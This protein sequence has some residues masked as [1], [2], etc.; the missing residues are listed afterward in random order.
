MLVLEE[1]IPGTQ[2]FFIADLLIRYPGQQARFFAATVT[3]I[4]VCAHQE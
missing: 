1:Q 3:Q 2:H 4:S